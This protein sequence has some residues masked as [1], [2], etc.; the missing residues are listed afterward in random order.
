MAPVQEIQRRQGT[1]VHCHFSVAYR[2]VRENGHAGAWLDASATDLSLKG[3]CLRVEEGADIPTRAELLFIPGGDGFSEGRSRKLI[4]SQFVDPKDRSNEIS[5]PI[6]VIGKLAH[7][8]LL[9]THEQ[10]I[11]FTFVNIPPVYQMRILDFMEHVEVAS[12]ASEEAA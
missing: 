7:S 3:I 11:G 6:K 1:R 9:K 10:R 2:T 12:S 4:G 8:H 5:T